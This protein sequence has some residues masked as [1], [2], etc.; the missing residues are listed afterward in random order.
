MVDLPIVDSDA[1]YE[2]LGKNTYFWDPEQGAIM[3]KGSE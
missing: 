2:A 3:Y 1:A